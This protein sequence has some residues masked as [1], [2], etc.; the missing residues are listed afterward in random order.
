MGPAQTRTPPPP[1]EPVAASWSSGRLC[2]GYMGWWILYKPQQL[3]VL[4]DCGIARTPVHDLEGRPF[5]PN[6]SQPYYVSPSQPPLR[7]PL[8]SPRPHLPPP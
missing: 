5:R 7:L 3:R 2:N 6:T 8:A 4:C 1:A